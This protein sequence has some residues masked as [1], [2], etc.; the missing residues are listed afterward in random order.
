M[1]TY[2]VN[3]ISEFNALSPS[4]GDII[5]FNS[6]SDYFRLTTSIVCVDG[7]TYKS[8]G[9]SKAIIVASINE[10]TIG[11][12]AD[13]GGNIWLN[14]DAN[15]TS[16]MGNIV[17]D[18]TPLIWVE[19]EGDLSEQGEYW[20]DRVNSQ[21]KVY[22]VGNP[23]TVYSILECC[24]T[25]DIFD[26]TPSNVIIENLELKY[27]AKHG[28]GF[29]DT[30]YCTIKNNTISYIGGGLLNLGGGTYQ[31]YG[32]AIEIF[33]S[34]NSNIIE[35]NIIYE[36]YDVALT[37]QTSNAEQVTDTYIQNNI[38]Y[39]CGIYGWEM[40]YDNVGCSID[41]LYIYNNT[42]INCSA[43]GWAKNQ[44]FANAYGGGIGLYSIKGTVNNYIIKNNLVFSD[45]TDIT[46]THKARCLFTGG[47]G[48]PDEDIVFD[49][50]LYY[51]ADGEMI[52]FE[53]ATYTSA[54][55][56]DY[57]TA[58]SQDANSISADPLLT[59]DY[60][61]KAGS[62]CLGT[63]TNVGVTKDYRGYGRKTTPDI[64]AYEYV[65]GI[66]NATLKNCTIGS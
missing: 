14:S 31:R 38:S 66:R 53:G 48:I 35:K 45:E 32:N 55:F 2:Q 12:W 6:A 43:G 8:F 3:N 25:I 19:N 15:F 59:S 29:D 10:N 64:G 30:N 65:S 50:N 26:G 11:D 24:L 41:G 5:E 7:V 13:Q 20:F 23:A 21:I 27:G 42:F 17:A 49:N 36:I 28:I 46:A 56:S 47:A 61:L 44:Y 37:I 58:K 4:S 16:G 52:Y 39:N 57:Q 51:R 63:G 60:M 54:Q 22:S 62:P 34:S 9:D 1:A 40:F 18:G 33:G